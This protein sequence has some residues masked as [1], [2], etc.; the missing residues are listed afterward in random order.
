MVDDNRKLTSNIGFI[1]AMY[2][3]MKG[4]AVQACSEKGFHHDPEDITILGGAAYN[5]HASRLQIDSMPTSDI[6]MTWWP[7]QMDTVIQSE[8]LTTLS[9]LVV[10]SIPKNSTEWNELVGSILGIKVSNIEFKLENVRFPLESKLNKRSNRPPDVIMNR[11]IELSMIMNGNQHFENIC[12]L[13]IR[14][15]LN[16][17]EYT[18]NHRIVGMDERGM[19]YDPTY[20]N[21]QNTAMI[22]SSRVPQIYSFTFQQLFSYKNL[23]LTS[24]IDKANIQLQRVINLY[25]RTQGSEIISQL[26]FV[27]RIILA[28]RSSAIESFIQIVGPIGLWDRMQQQIYQQQMMQQQMQQQ[29]QQQMQQQMMQQ[30]MMQQQM[31]QQQMM[32]QQ[33]Q[34]R[35]ARQ[36]QP[37]QQPPPPPMNVSGKVLTIEQAKAELIKI[38][39]GN[40]PI[41]GAFKRSMQ[42]IKNNVYSNYTDNIKNST[43]YEDSVFKSLIPKYK[44]TAEEIENDPS[45]IEE[46]KAFK[47][48]NRQLMAVFNSITLGGLRKKRTIKRKKNKSKTKKRSTR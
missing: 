20:C 17:Q 3:L 34:S 24:K 44:K 27:Y 25:L 37:R 15:A 35:K 14:N 10:G 39:D 4:A 43:K 21:Q 28:K 45:V 31:Y 5:L 2:Q 6:D 26:I 19:M 41:C 9:D 40:K 7:P 38:I 30:Q 33:M 8:E 48:V 18:L 32:Q 42:A 12:S 23:L 13:V 46:F 16:S 11:A 36:S 29:I 1:H 22:G 47:A